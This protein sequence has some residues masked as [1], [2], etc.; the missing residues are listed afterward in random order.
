LGLNKNFFS[1]ELTDKSNTLVDNIL[2]PMT[3]R[4]GLRTMEKDYRKAKISKNNID[5]PIRNLIRKFDTIENASL[6]FWNIDDIYDFSNRKFYKTTIGSFFEHLITRKSFNGNKIFF[7]SNKQVNFDYPIYDFISLIKLEE[8]DAY[9]IKLIMSR[10]YSNRNNPEFAQAIIEADND[11]IDSM[12]CGHPE[13]AKRFVTVSLKYGINSVLNDPIYQKEYEQEVK[14]KYINNELFK[15]I[16]LSD[17]FIA[18]LEYFALF[19]KM[20]DLTFFK[21]IKT[22]VP[23]KTLSE[24]EDMSMIQGVA[25]KSGEK[26]FYVPAL[27]K[28][29]LISQLIKN[30]E[31]FQDYHTKIGDFFWKKAENEGKALGIKSAQNSAIY[32][33]DKA[34]NKEK[35]KQIILRFKD[36][37]L[38][39]ALLLYNNREFEEAYEYF[40]DLFSKNE[41]SNKSHLNFLLKSAINTKKHTIKRVYDFGIDEYPIDQFMK[42]TYANYCLQSGKIEAAENICLEIL[43]DTPENFGINNFYANVLFE[44]GEH[45]EA[46]E[47]LNKW[48]KTFQGKQ[49]P[50]DN[51]KKQLSKFEDTVRKEVSVST[52]GQRCESTK[53]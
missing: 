26:A 42:T 32:H 50:S 5:D 10:E 27:I 37:F 47:L 51:D 17:D 16:Q 49:N 53:R 31:K 12:I 6:V 29:Y 11:K 35:E 23:P 34:E 30:K 25:S 52:I 13:L 4:F 41:L 19:K 7:V 14:I 36:L 24:L 48:I 43:T 18:I 15:K 1:I 39:K 3:E 38:E 9:N 28:S 21:T 44:K 8:I 2:V 22:F 45:D 46:F 33:Y 40:Y 20:I